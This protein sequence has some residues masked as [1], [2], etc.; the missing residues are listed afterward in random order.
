MENCQ[1]SKRII[2]NTS[3]FTGQN[4]IEEITCR[5]RAVFEEGALF[6]VYESEFECVATTI[7]DK[8]KRGG[9]RVFKREVHDCKVG[10]TRYEDNEI[11]EYVRY[12]FAIGDT[13]ACG[14]AKQICRTKQIG[15]SCFLCSVC[16]DTVLCGKRPNQ[17]FIDT[18]II[19][20]MPKERVASAYG[21]LFSMPF[22]AFEREFCSKI[23]DEKK[24]D[25]KTYK[26]PLDNTALALDLLEASVYNKWEDSAQKMANVL[27][28]RAIKEGKS[29][30]FFGEYRFIAS[31][32]IS[33][34]YS[35]LLRSPSIDVLPPPTAI[36]DC[37]DKENTFAISALNEGKCVDFFDINSYFRINYILGEY[38]MDLLER[39]ANIDVHGMQRFWR[40]L[41]GDAGYWLKG[42]I[43]A[44][45][46]IALLPVVGAKSDNLLGYAYASGIL[47]KIA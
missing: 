22:R 46:L 9:Y 45:E 21:N 29:P 39:L 13:Y 33:C 37:T 25:V 3:I 8:F 42:E 47:H 14:V 12:V 44:K 31:C 19:D 30:R 41:Y 26:T 36:A 20:K 16:D 27:R 10:E 32:L 34:F 38:R 7:A 6:V 35:N 40:R 15:W 43:T 17:V 2:G 1:I 28:E 11:P 4:L 23:L 18:D 5:L 24:E